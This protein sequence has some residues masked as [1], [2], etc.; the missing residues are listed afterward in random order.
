MANN[1]SDPSEANPNDAQGQNET[2][3]QPVQEQNLENILK[4]IKED[5]QKTQNI[6]LQSILVLKDET[7]GLMNRDLTTKLADKMSGNEKIVNLNNLKNKLEEVNKLLNTSLLCIEWLLSEKDNLE[8]VEESIRDSAR[9]SSLEVNTNEIAY[10]ENTI[11]KFSKIKAVAFPTVGGAVG[12]VGGG[13]VVAGTTVGIHTGLVSIAGI[14]TSIGIYG[15][16]ACGAGIVVAGG[17]VGVTVGTGVIAAIWLIKA[18]QIGK[19]RKGKFEEFVEMEKDFDQKRVLIKLSIV[20]NKFERLVKQ[21][22]Y[23]LDPG[24][25]MLRSRREDEVQRNKAV[26]EYH[27]V[28]DMVL[29]NP[30]GQEEERK[31]LAK[32]IAENAC[33][34]ALENDFVYNNEANFEIFLRERIQTPDVRNS[35]RRGSNGD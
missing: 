22:K 7:R 26:E 4:N 24:F 27:K 28:Y 12:G 8:R 3:H 5:H 34:T 17:L 16:A 10:F 1:N 6:V 29:N 31:A 23:R 2:D 18:Y 30:I 15:V 14:L 13:V 33:K 35:L 19:A 25:S 11:K 9:E 32:Q 21:V 20:S